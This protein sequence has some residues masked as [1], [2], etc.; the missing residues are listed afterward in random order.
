MSAGPVLEP[1]YTVAEISE[2][3]N[4]SKDAVRSLFQ[5]EPGVFVLGDI[6]TTRRKRRYTT[7]RIPE[8]VVERVYRRC[9]ISKQR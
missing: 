7:L 3:L 4:L 1:H 8:S 5:N 6:I 9:L 2:K